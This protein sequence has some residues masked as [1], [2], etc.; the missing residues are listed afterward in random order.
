[1]KADSIGRAR[2]M[3]MDDLVEIGVFAEAENEDE[4]GK[5]LYLQKHRIH[6]GAQIITV[7]VPRVPTRAGIDPYHRLIDRKRDD[8]IQ[9]VVGGILPDLPSRGSGSSRI[10]ERVTGG[11]TA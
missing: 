5:L 6:S 3:P 2:Q 8:N 1:M 10:P 7:T 9:G 11:S 4:R